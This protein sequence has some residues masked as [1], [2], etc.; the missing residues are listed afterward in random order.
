MLLFLVP[1]WSLG[2]AGSSAEQF[3]RVDID[4]K[5]SSY[6]VEIADT[7]ARRMQGL[8]HRTSLDKQSGMLFIYRQSAQHK[9]WMKNTLIP[10]TVIW[11]DAGAKIIDIKLLRPCEVRNCQVYGV[12]FPSSYILELHP[13]A[14]NLFEIGD[15]LPE[16]L[17]A[18]AQAQ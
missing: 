1:Q 6:Q 11:L 4:L 13:Q 3:R 17:N 7:V 9:I 18:V 8:M 5:G 10:L 16:I 15:R 14:V 2:D 12:K